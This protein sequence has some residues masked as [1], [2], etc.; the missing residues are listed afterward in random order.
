MLYRL[1]V[2]M[3]K[4]ASA[5]AARVKRMLENVEGHARVRMVLFFALLLMI[6]GV[7]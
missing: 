5:V 3:T 4:T 1:E 7:M 6:G 2:W